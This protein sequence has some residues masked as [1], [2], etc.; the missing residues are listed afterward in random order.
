MGFRPWDPASANAATTGDAPAYLRRASYLALSTPDFGTSRLGQ[1]AGLKLISVADLGA[2]VTDRK[3]V[4]SDDAFSLTFTTDSPFDAG[5]RTFAHPDLGVFDLFV[6]P[7]EGRGA[8]EV[9]VNRSVGIPKRVP[10]PPTTP[11]AQ[12]KPPTPAHVHAAQV[13]SARVRRVG[14][15][16][17]AQIALDPGAHVKSASVWLTRGG[18]VV[19]ASGVRHVNGRNRL[20]LPLPTGKRLRGGHYEL[21]VGTKGRHG[22]TEYKRVKIALQ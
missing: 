20:S 1:A 17:V 12:K 18:N 7:V 22:P 4:N 2:A 9:I 16:V 21:T 14:H 8:Y 10:Q 5:T 3:L 11:P 19:A 6:A 13:R 15:D